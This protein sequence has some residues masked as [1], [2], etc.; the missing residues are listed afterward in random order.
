MH[1]AGWPDAPANLLA[2]PCMQ[3]PPLIPHETMG[4]ADLY[5][6]CTSGA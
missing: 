1:G 3:N 5:Y 4:E 2:M 6:P